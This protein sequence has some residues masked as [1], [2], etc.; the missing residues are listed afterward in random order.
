MK[1]ID[2]NTALKINKLKSFDIFCKFY[3]IHPTQEKKILKEGEDAET[4]IFFNQIF[5]RK[6]DLRQPDLLFAT[7]Q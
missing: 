7:Y 4:P 6:P 2:R 1:V 3:Y 5:G